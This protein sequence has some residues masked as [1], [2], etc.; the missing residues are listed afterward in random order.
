M[1]AERA[2]YTNEPDTR[3]GNALPK[4]AAAATLDVAP[5]ER[6]F[7]EL[8]LEAQKREAGDSN[9][10]INVDRLAD[11]YMKQAGA[12]AKLEVG[13]D[14]LKESVAVRFNSLDSKVASLDAKVSSLSNVKWWLVGIVGAFE[15]LK[16]SGLS[17]IV[18]AIVASVGQ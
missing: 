18:K 10:A 5:E 13:Y 9:L 14:G 8:F 11:A 16:E 12:V 17:G 3:P 4:R 1:A 2:S 15:V 6:V 7:Q